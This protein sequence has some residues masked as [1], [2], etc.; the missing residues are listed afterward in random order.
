MNKSTLF[1]TA[2]NISRNA[3]EKFGGP[4]KSYFAESLKLAWHKPAAITVEALVN[5]GGSEWK[6][7]DMHRVYFNVKELLKFAGLE[8]THYK[9]G[10]VSSAKLHGE[11]ISNGKAT[12]MRAAFAASKFWF[13]VKSEKFITTGFISDTHFENIVNAINN[14]VLCTKSI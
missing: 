7:N 8:T 12:E 5:V 1:T 6:K 2:W 4:V 13:D 3:A 9:T 10:N 11:H 14:E